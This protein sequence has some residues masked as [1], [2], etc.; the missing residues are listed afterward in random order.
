MQE[1][2]ERQATIVDKVELTLEMYLLNRRNSVA[3]RPFFVYVRAINSFKPPEELRDDPTVQA[4]EHAA[5]DVNLLGNDILSY[6]KELIADDASHNVLTVLM[7]DSS[8]ACSDLQQAID[9]ASN[10]L[11]EALDHFNECRARLLEDSPDWEEYVHGLVDFFV[12]LLE[13]EVVSHRFN[14]FE[15]EEDRKNLVLRL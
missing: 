14:V 4:P 6:K 3:T 1:A 2:V 7:Q 12:G 13:W 10:L 11:V 15:S 9:Y 8:V 5:T